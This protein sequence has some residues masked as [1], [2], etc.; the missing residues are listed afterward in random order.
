[1]ELELLVTGELETSIPA[2][3]LVGKLKPPV[4][5]VEEDK[6]EPELAAPVKE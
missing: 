1:V 2:A 4:V 6:A 5:K 3:V